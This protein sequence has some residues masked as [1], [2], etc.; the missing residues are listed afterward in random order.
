MLEQNYTQKLEY[1]PAIVNNEQKNGNNI[2]LLVNEKSLS[3]GEI[4]EKICQPI[5]KSGI[6]ND[7][8]F[9]LPGVSMTPNLSSD[10]VV[11]N[12]EQKLTDNQGLASS[13]E[14][15]GMEVMVFDI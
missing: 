5:A 6:Q 11:A 12:C 8:L 13:A 7:C 1:S 9:M 10:V 3:S 4:Q 14:G 2:F 15:S